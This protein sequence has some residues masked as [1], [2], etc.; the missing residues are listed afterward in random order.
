MKTIII[1]SKIKDWLYRKLIAKGLQELR[2]EAYQKGYK[3]G[4]EQFEEKVAYLIN[5]RYTAQHWLV[6]PDEVLTVSDGTSGFPKG[7]VFLNGNKITEIEVKELKSEIKA[8]KNFRLWRILQETL[9][10]K[11]VEKSVLTSTNFEEVLAG[12]MMIHNIGII[13]SIVDVLDNYKF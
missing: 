8:F 6:N 10:Q 11:A 12:K 4:S 13:K 2:E 9:R 5:E 3:H 1:Y 7:V